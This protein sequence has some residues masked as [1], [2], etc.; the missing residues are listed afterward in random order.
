L[1]AW[2]AP[3]RPQFNQLFY[4]RGQ[5]YFYAFDAPYLDGRDLRELPLIERKRILQRIVPRSDSRLLYVGHIATRGVDLFREVC[6]QDLKSVTP[7][8]PYWLRSLQIEMHRVRPLDVFD[9]IQH[10]RAREHLRKYR[11]P[12]AF[13]QSTV[14]RCGSLVKTG[15]LV[16]ALERHGH[17]STNIRSQPSCFSS[18][19]DSSSRGCGST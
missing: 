14:S 11:N 12:L 15:A 2:T 13:G 4:R 5:Q 19:A 1:C 6:R 7:S 18:E 8:R 17:F 3:A 10:P 16:G 9:T